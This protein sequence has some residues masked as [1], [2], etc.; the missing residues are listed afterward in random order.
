MNKS[1]LSATDKVFNKLHDYEESNSKYIEE[2]IPLSVVNAFSLFLKSIC[3][4]FGKYDKT[5]SADNI[6]YRFYKNGNIE[7]YNHDANTY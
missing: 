4:Y 6:F 5:S 7:I 2:G 1:T 3:R